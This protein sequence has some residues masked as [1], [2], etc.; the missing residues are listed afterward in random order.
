MFQEPTWSENDVWKESSAQEYC[1]DYL[2]NST[3]GQL[4]SELPGVNIDKEIQ[5]CVEDIQVR[6]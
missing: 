1:V 4:C 3:V 6:C 2:R 5:T